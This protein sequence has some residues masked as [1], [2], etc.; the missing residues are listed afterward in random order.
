MFV[1]AFRQ[2]V[3]TI[4][5]FVRAFFAS[6]YITSCDKSLRLIYSVLGLTISPD[7]KGA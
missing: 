3:S 4:E 7:A 1:S 6:F 5:V 2:I